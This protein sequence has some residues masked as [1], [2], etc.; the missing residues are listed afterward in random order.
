MFISNKLKADHPF[1][2]ETLTSKLVAE[3]S[4]GTN[5]DI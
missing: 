2:C 5:A 3:V 4:N 1:K